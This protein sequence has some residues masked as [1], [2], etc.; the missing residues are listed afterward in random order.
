MWGAKRWAGGREEFVWLTCSAVGIIALSQLADPAPL[1][2]LVLL[3]PAL[4]A[5]AARGLM[6]RMAPEI[7]AVLV[8][9]PVAIVVSAGRGALEGTFFLVVVM[10][11]FVSWRSDSTVRASGVVLAAVVSPWLVNRFFIAPHDIGWE[12][13]STASVFTFAMGR[14]L[15]RQV[16]LIEELQRARVTL[17][18]QAV[19]EERRRIA[20]ELH[21][22]AG[23]TL[24]AVL[25]HVTG[26]RH[27]LRRDVEEAERALLDAE[28][29]GR[30]SLDQIRAAVATL[31]TDERGTDPAL[32]GPGDLAALVEEYRRAGLRMSAAIAPLAARVGGPVGTA[33]H[34]IVREAL[35]NVAR[36]APENDVEVAVDCVGSEVRLV[37]VDR[38]RRPAAPEL[39]ATH[40]GIIGMRE[41]ARALGG[42]LEAGPTADGW[43]VEAHLPVAA[44]A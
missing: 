36:H 7:F 29:V 23:H 11:L 31:R 8:I 39:E 1:G 35:A 30:S 3:A 34:R 33:V 10:V 9:V 12:A 40:F 37:V 17:A 44:S 4:A 21:D 13:W 14:L 28:S 42:V 41:R 22:L 25:L 32:A 6:S 43:L 19:A 18:E 15:R 5:F 38:G 20:R 2:R 27:V 26:A 24:A 16:T